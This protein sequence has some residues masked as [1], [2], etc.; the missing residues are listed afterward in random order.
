MG[1]RCETCAHYRES[2]ER[3]WLGKCLRFPPSV[4]AYTTPG[5]PWE[6]K[7]ESRF[8]EVGHSDWCAEYT[9]PPA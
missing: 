5:D 4:I 1:D 8:P 3:V 7:Y 6:P 2:A 9:S